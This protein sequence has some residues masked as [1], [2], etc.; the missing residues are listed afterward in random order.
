VKNR[1]MLTIPSPFL[2]GGII[3]DFQDLRDCFETFVRW[4]G[5]MKR[6]LDEVVNVEG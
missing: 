1:L 6:V 5:K 2:S 4:I 3:V